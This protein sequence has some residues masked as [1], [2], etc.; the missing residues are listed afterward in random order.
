MDGDGGDDS[1][2][3]VS[4][5]GCESFARTRAMWRKHHRAASNAVFWKE[6]ERMKD[7]KERWFAQWQGS[8]RT[9]ESL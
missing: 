5:D 1:A 7:K 6:V 3:R 4:L 2:A 9:S 8:T